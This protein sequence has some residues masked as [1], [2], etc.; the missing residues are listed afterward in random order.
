M[1]HFLKACSYRLLR[2]LK[3]Y[4]MEQE[5]F[6]WEFYFLDRLLT[7]IAPE[8]GAT[9]FEFYL[10]MAFNEIS[11]LLTWACCTIFCK[12]QKLLR[13]RTHLFYWDFFFS[14]IVHYIPGTV[15]TASRKWPQPHIVTLTKALTFS[16][17]LSFYILNA[18]DKGGSFV[19][20]NSGTKPLLDK[21]QL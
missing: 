16:G 15:L 1:V 19:T 4:F 14:I 5:M 6:F 13:W 8:D 9:T 7:N 20:L 2:D 10:T 21:L 3:S 12:C 17:L 18:S 11:N